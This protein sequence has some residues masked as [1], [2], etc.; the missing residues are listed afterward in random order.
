[1]RVDVSHYVAEAMARAKE[2]DRAEQLV[3]EDAEVMDGLPCFAG[4]RVPI[5]TVLASL[6][7]GIAKDR[8]I[9]SYPFLT[10]AHIDAARVYAQVHPRR[11]RPRRLSDLNPSATPR[12]T[13]VVRSAKA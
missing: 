4:S 12:V 3:V 2:V 6:E 13:R 11:G 9:T 5:E 10:E 7:R 8:L 1:V